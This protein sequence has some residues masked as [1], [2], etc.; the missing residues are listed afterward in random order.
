MPAVKLSQYLQDRPHRRVDGGAHRVDG[1]R[2]A[3]RHRL[4]P[5][6]HGA[7]DCAAHLAERARRAP[8]ALQS[9]AHKV[10]LLM[11]LLL[12]FLLVLGFLFMF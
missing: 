5:A 1:V 3:V 8:H 7:A 2:H 12:L 10:V 6:T 4:A 9:R 11:L